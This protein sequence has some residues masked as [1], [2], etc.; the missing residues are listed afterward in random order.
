MHLLYNNLFKIKTYF[1][2]VPKLPYPSINDQIKEIEFD[3]MWHFIGEKK[4]KM[5]HQSP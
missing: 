3:E 5:D 2:L 1:V 4:Q